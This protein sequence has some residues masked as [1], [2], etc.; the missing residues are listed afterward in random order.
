MNID[1]TTETELERTTVTECVVNC[2]AEVTGRDPI[3]LPPLW[4]VIDPDALN[5]LVKPTRSGHQRVGSVEFS[6]CDHLVTVKN[7]SESGV[8]IS[9]EELAP[10]A[11]EFD[12]ATLDVDDEPDASPR[13]T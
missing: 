7:G 11:L 1:V 5:Q 6:Y 4:D 10:S 8:T 12:A 9:L 2:L 13:E 3:T